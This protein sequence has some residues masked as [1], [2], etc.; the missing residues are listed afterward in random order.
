MYNSKPDLIKEL[1]AALLSATARF[2]RTN[3]NRQAVCDFLITQC[4]FPGDKAELFGDYYVK[5]YAEIE[6]SLLNVGNH[7][8]HISDVSWKIDYIIKVLQIHF[9]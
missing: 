2:V 9:C 4:N 8:P 3:Q 7:L 1:Y 5:N 6:A